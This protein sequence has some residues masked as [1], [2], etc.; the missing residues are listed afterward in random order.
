M[1]KKEAE[2][3]KTTSALQTY[4]CRVRMLTLQEKEDLWHRICIDTGYSLEN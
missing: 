1:A 2:T 4:T 3:K